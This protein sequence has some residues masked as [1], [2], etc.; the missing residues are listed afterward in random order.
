VT[1]GSAVLELPAGAAI[2]LDGVE[3][4]VERREPH[5][6]RVHLVRGDGTRQQVSMR[7][8]AAAVSTAG[9]LGKLFGL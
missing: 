2:V 7:F 5:L 1:A 9:S 8:P 3:W 4:T 6:G